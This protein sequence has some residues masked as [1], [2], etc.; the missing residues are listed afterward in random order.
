MDQHSRKFLQYTDRIGGDRRSD[1]RYNLALGVR[2]NLLY[3]KKVVDSGI[4]RTVDLSS[5]GI[6]FEAGLRL[7]AGL[8][9]CLAISWPV[10]L[11]ESTQMQ[12][13]VEGRIVRSTAAG[14]A[15]R[16]TQHEFRTATAAPRTGE[17]SGGI[18]V[19]F[20]FRTTEPTVRT[21]T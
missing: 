20:P 12:L 6:L 19:P 14:V 4:G 8:K 9:V 2:W 21:F 5:G 10:L 16:T 11:H 17:L 1:R 15:I 3:R 13:I 7:P 18:R